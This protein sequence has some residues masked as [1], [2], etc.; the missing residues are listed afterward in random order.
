MSTHQH[1]H[2]LFGLWLYILSDCVLFAG[3]F[4]TF[5]VLRGQT[6][7]NLS[8]SDLLHLSTLLVQTLVLLTS[9][10]IIGLTTQ[11]KS[12][13]VILFGL[14]ATFI[15]GLVFIGFE[16]QEFAGLVAAGAGPG[17]S[18]F[19]SSFFVLVGT[20]GL[21]VAVGMLWMLIL[22]VQVWLHGTTHAFSRR[23]T[24][25]ALF[26]HFLDIVWIAIFS[27]VYLLSTTL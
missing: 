13:G 14:A 12:R 27:I 19:L 25:L 16:I 1:N 18:A 21:H 22:G 4:A 9:S 5:A 2:S 20:H 23:L 6:F 24:M 17:H 8:G 15:L 11:A 7:G 26:W 10:M 3:L